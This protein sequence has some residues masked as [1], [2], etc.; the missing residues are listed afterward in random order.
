MRLCEIWGVLNV[1]PDSFSDG[2]MYLRYDAA[3]AHAERM[4]ADGADVIDIGGASSRPAGTL[5]GDGAV[6]VSAEEE[7]ARVRPLVAAVSGQLGARVSIDTTNAEVAR[8]AIDA[9]AVI[10]ND[11]SCAAS[12]ALLEL[13]AERRVEYVVMHNRGSG[14]VEPPNTNYQ[15]V[16]SDVLDELLAAAA[17]AISF[18]V[19]AER[20]WLDPGLGFAKT[21]A[22]SLALLARTETFVASGFRVL[23]GPS[24]KGFIADRAQ[25]PNGAR[26]APAA[27]DP[28][29][30]AAITVAVLQGARAVRVH[31]VSAARQAVLLADAV[32]REVRPC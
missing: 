26:P 1:T 9:G 3:L 19:A 10:V 15:A 7:T 22:Q 24:R 18:G 30:L 8:A 23:C 13:V 21:A 4:L 5:Y 32:R 11:V 2:G 6:A 28:G 14:A 27:R 12:D 17:R 31:E 16:V 29:T 20:L 25:L